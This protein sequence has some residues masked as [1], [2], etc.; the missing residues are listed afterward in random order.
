MVKKAAAAGMAAAGLLV[1][2]VPALAAATGSGT[3][4]YDQIGGFGFGDDSDGLDNLSLVCSVDVNAV[5]AI[6]IMQGNDGDQ[7]CGNLEDFDYDYQYDMEMPDIV[8]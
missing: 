3:Q 5:I 4:L 6:P 1:L 2:G 7:A 8:G